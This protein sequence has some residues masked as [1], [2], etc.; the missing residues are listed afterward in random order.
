MTGIDDGIII[1]TMNG[2]WKCSKCG[3]IFF[4]LHE[5]NSHFPCKRGD[6]S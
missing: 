2:Q 4:T 1:L 6:I 5:G 3:S